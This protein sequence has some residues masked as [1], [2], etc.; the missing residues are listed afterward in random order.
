MKWNREESQ[1][2]YVLHTRPYRESSLLVECFSKNHGRISLVAK[3]VRR[4][5]S[6]RA[7]LLQ[8]F[9]PL[10]ISWVGRTELFTLCQMEAACAQQLFSG[11]QLLCGLY[12]NEL[13][14]RLLQREDPH[15]ELYEAYEHV[16]LELAQHA[17]P[18]RALRFFE[19]ALLVSLGY[20]FSFDYIER[21]SHYVFEA[22]QGLIKTAVKSNDSF[23]GESILALENENLLDSHL[24]EIKRLMRVALFGLLN[25]KPLK[26]RELFL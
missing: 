22:S 23:S 18:E 19:K 5:K 15:P 9:I 1:P 12:T 20:A 21:E 8:P 7:G 3:G 13:L 26:T 2:V 25:D 11:E 10:L 6:R 17:H 14:L 4:A 16:L 24:K